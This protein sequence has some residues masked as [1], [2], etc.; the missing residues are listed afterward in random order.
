MACR[1]A[2][3]VSRIQREKLAEIGHK[4][5]GFKKVSVRCKKILKA[6]EEQGPLSRG[7]IMKFTELPRGTID[8]YLCFLKELECIKRIGRKYM[9]HSD[10]VIYE[11]KTDRDLALEHSKNIASGLLSMINMARYTVEG[12][13]LTPNIRYREHALKHLKTALEYR[14]IYKLFEE[15]EQAKKKAVEEEHKLR[16][17]V[18]AKLSSARLKLA[19]EVAEIVAMG[20]CED[21]KRILKDHK[22]DFLVNL[23]VEYGKVKSGAYTLAEEDQFEPLRRFIMSEEKSEDI[24]GACGR[25]VNLS[26]KHSAT[27]QRFNE[28]AEHLIDQVLNGTPMKGKCNLCPKVISSNGRS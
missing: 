20:V 6:L 2:R 1:K 4:K 23:K 5:S 24:M 12:V 15:A 13:P 8:R 14:K 19:G 7:Q 25:I 22:P 17:W 16:E 28:L 3:G 18:R 11:N 21:V 26:E 9:L 27:W 10:T